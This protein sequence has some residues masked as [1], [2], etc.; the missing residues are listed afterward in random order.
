MNK[1]NL[2]FDHSC[3]ESMASFAKSGTQLN[4]FSHLVVWFFIKHTLAVE[5]C[6]YTCK[7]RTVIS[8]SE[9]KAIA[10]QKQWARASKR[11]DFFTICL[12][13]LNLR[14]LTQ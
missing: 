7:L 14:R 1:L 2:K 3:I 13:L 5:F 10:E 4:E 12:K 9:Q 8:F 11:H 6:I